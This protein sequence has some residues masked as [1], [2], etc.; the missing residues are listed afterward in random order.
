MNNRREREQRKINDEV[1]REVCVRGWRVAVRSEPVV[2][3]L[4]V[5]AVLRV[6]VEMDCVV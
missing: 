2:E 3:R 5:M 1:S 4:V 6:V